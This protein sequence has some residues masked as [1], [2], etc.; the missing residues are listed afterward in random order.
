MPIAIAKGRH[1][2]NITATTYNTPDV[3]GD[4]P[5][6]EAELDCPLRPNRDVEAVESQP[7]AMYPGLD[8][9]GCRAEH[10]LLP[11]IMSGDIPRGR[12]QLFFGSLKLS[13]M[14]AR[15]GAS[16]RQALVVVLDKEKLEYR[17]RFTIQAVGA[18]QLG[19]ALFAGGLSTALL[20]NAVVER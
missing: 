9:V 17:V 5:R 13:F 4:A 12:E 1:R 2:I 11:R 16:C 15:F 20:D 18:E 14:L 10:V 8:R 3:T 6:R 19:G 7:V